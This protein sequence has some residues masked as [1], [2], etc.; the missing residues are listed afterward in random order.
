MKNQLI[1]ADARTRQ[2]IEQEFGSIAEFKD[3]DRFRQIVRRSKALGFKGA[4]CIHPDQARIL[5]EEFR[6]SA[7]EVERASGIVHAYNEAYA[8]GRGSVTF[9]GKMIDVPIVQ[10]AE[11]VLAWHQAIEAR[12]QRRLTARP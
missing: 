7:A 4:S 1:A 2:L 10:R 9:E 11:A 8:A 12:A 5:N 3:L 6:P